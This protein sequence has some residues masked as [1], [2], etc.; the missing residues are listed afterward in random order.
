LDGR[1]VDQDIDGAKFFDGRFNGPLT[2]RLL[3]NI[4]ADEMHSVFIEIRILDDI[5]A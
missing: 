5:G 1:V 2:I 3:G 4:R